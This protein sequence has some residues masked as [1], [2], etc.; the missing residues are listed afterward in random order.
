MEE[1]E[2]E[3][4]DLEQGKLSAKNIQEYCWSYYLEELVLVS[5]ISSERLR[6]EILELLGTE[7]TN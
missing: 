2:G 7:E 4:C 5:S 1:D 3:G 6:T